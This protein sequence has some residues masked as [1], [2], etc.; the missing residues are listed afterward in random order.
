MLVILAGIPVAPIEIG[1]PGQINHVCILRNHTIK[2]SLAVPD[3][4][5]G[6]ADLFG[7]VVPAQAG[8]Q[9]NQ[10]SGSPPARG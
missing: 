10:A 7:F 4:R 2:A 3:T 8:T 6:N 5:Y 9:S 1:N